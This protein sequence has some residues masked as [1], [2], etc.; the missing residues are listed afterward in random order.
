MPPVNSVLNLEL[1]GLQI[2]DVVNVAVGQPVVPTPA[3]IDRLQITADVIERRLKD[4][5]PTYGVNTGFGNSVRN[6]VAR[7]HATRLA[8]NLPRYHGC[9]VAPL[10]SEE[11]CRAVVATRIASLSAGYSGVRPLIVEHLCKLLSAGVAPVI[12]SRGSV[13][14]SGDLTPLSYVAALLVGEREA[15]LNGEIVSSQSA[16][17]AAGVPATPLAPKESLAIM[18][19]TSVMVA[20]TCL[21]FVRA[22]R[23][24]RLASALT[25][26]MIEA[27]Q[28]QPAHFDERLFLA[29]PHPGQLQC[30]AWIRTALDVPAHPPSRG[31]RIQERYSLRCAPHV[32]GVLLDGLR[33]LRPVMTTEINGANDN[34]LIDPETGDVLHGGN[35]YGGHAAMVADTLKTQVA[36]MADLMERQL[37]LLNDP[38]QNGGLPENLVAVEGPDRYAH[39]GFKAMEI[40]A[41]SLTAEALKATMPA[42][43]FSRSTEQHN[44]DKV[45]MGSIAAQ[46]LTNIVGLTESV[47]AVHL[48]ACAQAVDVRGVANV[49]KPVAVL[50]A[51]IRAVAPM[52]HEDRR[53]D[54]DIAA[55]LDLLRADGLPLDGLN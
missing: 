9:G 12:P 35:F 7:E 11:V 18:N 30:A 10:H 29:K 13:G 26:M 39:H 16:L 45:S 24:A 34:P 23:L 31:P 50:H 25:A 55:V 15:Y 6:V 28:G 17:D 40:T 22:E 38:A 43:V 32:I 44:Q 51:A 27:T 37:V 2:E 41:S 47:A 33:L 8:Q 21:S 52:V 5:V 20:E 42:S 54:G 48:L 4:N 46:D 49:S 1:N 14:A 53:M 36:N 3:L 19:G